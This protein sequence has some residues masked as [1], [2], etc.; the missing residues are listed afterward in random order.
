MAIE[1]G[2]VNAIRNM[3]DIKKE[4]QERIFRGI[5]EKRDELEKEMKVKND[6]IEE[7]ILEVN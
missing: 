6:E 1:R 2:N 4:E 3:N 5:V 7:L